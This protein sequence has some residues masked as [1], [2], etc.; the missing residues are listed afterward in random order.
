MVARNKLRT[1]KQKF[2]VDEYANE[3]QHLCSH[4][5]KSHV[6]RGDKVERFFY[7]PKEDV[8]S[9]VLVDPWG[10]GGPWE[11]IKHLINYV[12]TIEATYTL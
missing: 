3:F 2:Y 6:S 8:R 12:V 11:D 7:G 4:I 1:L 9:K 5:T 10:D